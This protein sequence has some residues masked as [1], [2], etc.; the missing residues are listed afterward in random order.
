[1][2][3]YT[4][5]VQTVLTKDQFET[6]SRI[7]EEQHKPLSLLIREAVEEVY[8]TPAELERRRKALKELLSLNAPVG[9]WEEMR[10]EI[11]RGAIGDWDDMEG[12]EPREDINQGGTE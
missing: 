1:M 2:S 5:R 11:I 6:L 9:D 10:E 8:I 7:A 3:R 4:Q 12:W